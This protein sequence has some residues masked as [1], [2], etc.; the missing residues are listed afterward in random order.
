[1]NSQPTAATKLLRAKIDDNRGAID[2]ALDKYQASN[3]RLLKFCPHRSEGVMR[4]GVAEVKKPEV[5]T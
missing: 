5:L 3:L 2:A 1:M 4:S